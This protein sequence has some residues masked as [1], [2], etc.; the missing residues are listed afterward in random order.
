MCPATPESKGAD[1]LRPDPNGWPLR[2]PASVNLT[3]DV[4][5]YLHYV[6]HLFIFIIGDVIFIFILLKF[7]ANL[8]LDNSFLN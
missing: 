5:F 8:F 7:G 2:R 6:T 4:T 1:W 3:G